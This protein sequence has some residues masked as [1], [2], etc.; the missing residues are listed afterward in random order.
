MKKSVVILLFLA[1]TV[2]NADPVLATNDTPA[3]AWDSL[4]GKMVNKFLAANG[5]VG[6]FA[7]YRYNLVAGRSY[8]LFCW[9]AF[10]DGGG[11]CEAFWANTSGAI[12]TA[13]G[14]N[15]EPIVPGAQSRRSTVFIPTTSGAYLGFLDN[16]NASAAT[17]YMLAIETT[18][19]SPW[20]FID[21]G[22]GYDG[23]VEIKNNTNS[24]VDVTVTAYD[25]T[26]SVVGTTT[27]TISANGNTFVQ[28]GATF[29]IAGGF[30]SVDLAH[31]G[32]PGAVSANIT[33]LSATTGLSFDS[34]FTPRMSW[35][36]FN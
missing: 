11:A 26:G 19:F 32:M 9:Q 20:Y 35:S 5:A 28:I 12:L 25:S 34:P 18:L 8:R 17:T 15:T 31:N 16:D 30:G 36:T 33:T 1:V 29:G 2:L 10:A 7:Y 14:S 4:L 13:F 23:F 22:S 27:E 6:Q 3:N 21:S 24:S